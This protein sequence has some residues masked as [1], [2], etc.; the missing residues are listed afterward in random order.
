VPQG[1][2]L[3]QVAP[4]TPGGQKLIHQ[5]FETVIVVTL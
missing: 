2:A 1:V 3:E 4:D 5:G